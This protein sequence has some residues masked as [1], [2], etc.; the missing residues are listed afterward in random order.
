MATALRRDGFTATR[1]TQVALH[2]PGGVITNSSGDHVVALAQTFSVHPSYL[3][4]RGRKA[5]HHRPGGGGNLQ[6]RYGQRHRDHNLA[7]IYPS[8]RDR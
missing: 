7:C 1:L 2:S 8:E 4:D 3:F 5:T 6:G